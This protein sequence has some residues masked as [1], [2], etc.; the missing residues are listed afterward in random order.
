MDNENN[1]NDGSNKPGKTFGQF[2]CLRHD[3]NR[4]FYPDDDAPEIGPLRKG[5]IF[6][7]TQGCWATTVCRLRRWAMIECPM[8]AARPVLKAA[9]WFMHKAVEIAAGICI[10]P[11]I[12]IGPGLYIGHFGGIFFGTD[13]R[14]GVRVGMYC[15]ISQENTIGFG[16]RGEN[17][18]VPKLGDFV[19]LGAGA[20]VIGRI[21]IGDNVAVGAVV[22][23]DLPDNAVAAGVPA[24]VINMRGSRDFIHFCR[25]RSI[26]A[27]N[28]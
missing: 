13:V 25:R 22:T 23:K 18:G 24:R 12:D 6:I 10:P 9:G 27:E 8:P 4:Y 14:D 17:R 3:L 2:T 11:D 5:R 19:H 21:R 15:N 28:G 7:S 1:R 16:G 20:K 26:F